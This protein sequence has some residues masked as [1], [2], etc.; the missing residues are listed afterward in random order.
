MKRFGTIVLAVLFA[1]MCLPS[2]GQAQPGKGFALLKEAH[3]LQAKASS[4]EG[5]EHALEKSREALKIF[6]THKARLGIGMALHQMAMIHQKLGQYA[7]AIECQEKAL[8]LRRKMADSRGVSGTLGDLANLNSSMGRHRKALELLEKA[9]KLNA[10]AGAGPRDGAA[11]IPIARA[12]SKLGQ[13]RRALEVAEK[14]RELA[15]KT[16]NSRLEEQIL[17]V[18]GQFNR[19]LGR[20]Q[21]ALDAYEAALA[22]NRMTRLP[23]REAHCLTQIAGVHLATGEYDKAP[24]RYREALKIAEELQDRPLQGHILS[25]LG[26]AYAQTEDYPA[27][28]KHIRKGIE[29][30]DAAG[31]S[32]R[33]SKYLLANLC[34]DMGDLDKAEPLVKEAN[35]DAGFARL[36]L[37]RNDYRT[38]ETHYQ[39]LLTWGERTGNVNAL[40]SAYTGLAKVHEG[41]EDYPKAEQFYSEAVRLTEEIRSGL[42]PAERTHFFEV[43]INGFSRLEPARGLTRVRML[44]NRAADSIE[45][46]ELTR[47]RSFAE[48][49]S[50]RSELGTAGV[51][52]EVL[53]KEDALTSELASLKKERA[54]IDRERDPERFKSLTAEIERVRGE[55]DALIETLWAH[56]RP[57]AAVKY[58]RPVSLGNSAVKPEERLVIFDVLGE[59]VGVKLVEGKKITQTFFIRW[60]LNELEQDIHHFRQPFELVQPDKFD[61]ELAHKLYKKLLAAVL[62]NV[63]EGAP[64][65]IVPDG[66]LAVLPFEAL[67]VSGKA[68]AQ[69]TKSGLSPEGLTWLADV[70]PISYQQSLTALTLARTQERTK[71]GE[72]LLVVADPVFHAQ[73][74]RLT[75]AAGAA[76][77]AKEDQ[78]NIRLMSAIEAAEEG[79]FKFD[80]LARTSDLAENLVELFRGKGEMLTG[81][82]A[83]KGEFLN[84]VAPRLFN[85]GWIVFATH[86][87]VSN[88]VPGLTEPFLALT[89]VIPGTDGFLKMT[90]IMG[91]SLSADVVALP[92]C[93]TG[94]GKELSGEGV[95]SM[96]RAFQ[97]AGA[98]SV[99]MTLWSVAEDSSVQLVESFFRHVR[100]GRSKLDALALARQEIRESGYDH[101]FFW[102]PFILVGEAN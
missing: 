43:K 44:Q 38:A 10:R 15:Q 60:P 45:S 39:R 12:L 91:L 7:E 3:S 18:M 77:P 102:A 50:R 87:L 94:L 47:A 14:A 53:E 33:H 65:T 72:H 9:E 70:H 11:L 64:V 1:W 16:K 66:P 5:L 85:Y 86:G 19:N 2:L 83:N 51:P 27:A 41:L 84:T 88:K 42:L 35:L 61:A 82:Q 6:E 56:H 21:Q 25:S 26:Q 97:Y 62:T 23:R 24:A 71:T 74:E 96:G 29:I 34:M 79:G 30:L 49:L 32:T 98:R 20:Y 92:A 68:R 57:Y 67:V 78:R 99:L 28:L 17:L 80:R 55:L 31:I 52:N 89:M 54:E 13:N 37:L 22:V 36:A 95:M 81:L 63:P 73:D 8:E 4:K 59:G 101:P 75:E 48:G 69:K 76:R 100:E 58:P 93:Q 90:D 46:S 40:F